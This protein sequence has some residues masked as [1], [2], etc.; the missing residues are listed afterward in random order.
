MSLYST[1]WPLIHLRA[2]AVVV[3]A[4]QYLHTQCV[5]QPMAIDSD[6]NNE[7]VATCCIIV[8]IVHVWYLYGYNV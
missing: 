7:S 6:E 1:D 2:T 4:M 8:S 5:T 3:H